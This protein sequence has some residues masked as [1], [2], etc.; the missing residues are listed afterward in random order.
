MGRC[1]P[2]LPFHIHRR[3]D[4]PVLLPAGRN[5]KFEVGDCTNDLKRAGH[6][7]FAGA[8]LR[9]LHTRSAEHGCIVWL[10]PIQSGGCISLRLVSSNNISVSPCCLRLLNPRR[11]LLYKCRLVL[12]V[13]PHPTFGC[14]VE[15]PGSLPTSEYSFLRLTPTFGLWR[16]ARTRSP[17]LLLYALLLPYF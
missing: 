14:T 12:Q 4:A 1:G 15:P 2:E 16:R 8:P 17:A 6:S 7:Y 3:C 10:V 9:S 5:G 11:T 13:A